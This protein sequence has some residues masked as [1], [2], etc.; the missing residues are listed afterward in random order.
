MGVWVWRES[1]PPTYSYPYQTNTVLIGPSHHGT[2]TIVQPCWPLSLTPVSSFTWQTV[3]SMLLAYQKAR[4]SAFNVV[5]YKEDKIINFINFILR[6]ADRCSRKSLAH[7]LR[8][9]F[10]FFFSRGRDARWPVKPQRKRKQ[11]RGSCQGA[12]RVWKYSEVKEV[13]ML[14]SEKPVPREPVCTVTERE[15][16]TWDGT[17]A[18]SSGCVVC[19][20]N[21]LIHYY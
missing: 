12:R 21:R 7:P 2:R 14:S 11:E 17:T 18:F 6:V 5:T 3:W 20:Y 10:F 8:C 15:R 16:K 9:F 4:L 13:Q 19:S 1:H